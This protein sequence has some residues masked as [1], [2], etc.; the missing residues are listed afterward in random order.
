MRYSVWPKFCLCH[1][2]KDEFPELEQFVEEE[3]SCTLEDLLFRDVKSLTQEDV[4]SS[5]RDYYGNKVL[6]TKFTFTF[7]DTEDV[8]KLQVC[9]ARSHVD[10]WH[11]IIDEYDIQYT[12]NGTIIPCSK[13]EGVYP[14]PSMLEYLENL[15]REERVQKLLCY[16]PVLVFESGK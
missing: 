9:P 11:L 2:T 6:T 12:K 1:D 16:A 5:I 14:L 13:Y 15:P 3:V 4:K 7:H 10:T 8:Y